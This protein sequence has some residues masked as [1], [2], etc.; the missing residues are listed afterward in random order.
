VALHTI[1]PSSEAAKELI[2]QE[3]TRVEGALSRARALAAVLELQDDLDVMIRA[4][5]LI[6]GRL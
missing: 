3:M 2:R 4:A 1:K 5:A 6:N